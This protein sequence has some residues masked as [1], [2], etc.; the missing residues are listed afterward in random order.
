MRAWKRDLYRWVAAGEHH[1]EVG[2]MNHN[3]GKSRPPASGRWPR[4]RK[5]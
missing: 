2:D 4:A 1:H 5:K 3:H